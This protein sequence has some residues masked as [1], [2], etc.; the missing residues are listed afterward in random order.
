VF[1]CQLGAVNVWFGHSGWTHFEN[2]YLL[3]YSIV[4]NVK[5]T[6]AQVQYYTYFGISNGCMVKFQLSKHSK[7]FSDENSLGQVA[8]LSS[9]AFSS[10]S[11]G[12]E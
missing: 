7:Y 3:S 8:T 9:C 1:Q 2:L 4:L 10:R 11:L 6:A 12:G 5:E